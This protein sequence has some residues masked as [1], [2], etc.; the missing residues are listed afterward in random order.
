[1]AWTSR[2][3]SRLLWARSNIDSINVHC[4][5]DEKRRREDVDAMLPQEEQSRHKERMGGK[6]ADRELRARKVVA[7]DAATEAHV[8]DNEDEAAEADEQAK[9]CGGK[10]TAGKK[11]KKE[12]K[13]PEAKGPVN[14]TRCASCTIRQTEC[15]ARVVK[16][17]RTCWE[18]KHG[19]L[20]CGAG[21]GIDISMHRTL[22]KMTAELF[23]FSIGN[24]RTSI[25]IKRIEGKIDN[26]TAMMKVVMEA[27]GGVD[28]VEALPREITNPICTRLSTGCWEAHAW[29]G[30]SCR[31]SMNVALWE[32]HPI[33]INSERAARKPTLGFGSPIVDR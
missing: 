28:A 22:G 26:L 17:A 7:G 14:E 9:G 31:R 30:R 16:G 23:D 33:D 29:I 32:A 27:I 18:C 6:K 12:T 19:H 4:R 11:K 1:M 21:E 10:D 13:V 24:T 25:A 5:H 15:H 20:R 2:L 8:V 3:V